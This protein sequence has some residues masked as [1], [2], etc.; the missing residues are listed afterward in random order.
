[1]LVNN[2]YLL[3]LFHIGIVLGVFHGYP[4]KLLEDTP[5]HFEVQPLFLSKL[6]I[7]LKGVGDEAEGAER[8]WPQSVRGFHQVFSLYCCVLEP[9]IYCHSL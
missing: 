9:A 8:G 5:A 2:N 4:F 1:M 6:A 3:F 7:M